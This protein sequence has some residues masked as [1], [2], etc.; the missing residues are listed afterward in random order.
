MVHRRLARAALI[1]TLALL[2]SANQAAAQ[3]AAGIHIDNFGRINERYYRGAQPDGRDYADLAALGVKTVIDLTRDGRKDED[4]LVAAAG[5][6]F[7]RIPL[8]TWDRPS[9]AAVAQFLKLVTDPANL[10]VYVHCQG[11]RHRTGVM[12][13]VYRMTQDGWSADQAYAEMKV[14]KFEGFPGHPELK[15][16]VYDTFAQLQTRGSGGGH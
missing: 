7:Q 1:S 16:F 15:K 5:M 13:A 2:G 4:R 6:R 8:T 3:E 14:F 12:T 11:G 10:P 9:E